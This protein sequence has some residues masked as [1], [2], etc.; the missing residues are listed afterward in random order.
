MERLEENEMSDCCTKTKE[1]SPEQVR[2]LLNRLRRI[3]GQIR[4]ISGMVEASAYCPDILNQV[5]AAE[6]AL[7]AFARELLAS[8]IKTCVVKDIREGREEVLDELMHTLGRFL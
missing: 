7:A 8:H 3:E 2:A 5:A 6:S 4:G 1:R